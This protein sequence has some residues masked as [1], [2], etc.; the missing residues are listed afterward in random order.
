MTTVKVYDRT[1][2]CSFQL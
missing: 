2:T 1:M